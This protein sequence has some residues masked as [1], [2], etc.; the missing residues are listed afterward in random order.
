MTRLLKCSGFGFFLFALTAPASF[1][2]SASISSLTAISTPD[3]LV[4]IPIFSIG[5]TSNVVTVSTVD[6]GNPDQYAQQ[7]NRV[8]ASVTIA[9]VTV[10]PS[11]AV[12]GTFVICGP[13][14]PGCINPT[15]NNFSFVSTG[16][17]FSASS[18]TQL[19]LS[20]VARVGCPLI[21][22]GYFSFCGD[23]RPGAGL[24]Y[25]TDGS[26][27]EI[28]STQD[29]VGTTL[30]ASSLGDG[31]S[32][33]NRVTGCEQSFIESGNEWHFE[34]SWVRNL[35]G[36][37]DI[38]MKNQWLVMNVGDGVTPRGVGGE[39]AMSGTRKLAT[40][41][42]IG[43]RTMLIDMGANPPGTAWPSSGILRFR[44][45]STACWENAGGTNGLCQGTD[46]KDRFNFDG[47][48]VTPTY[49]TATICTNF[50]GQCNSAAAGSVGLSLGASSLIV[51]TTA[52]TSQSQIFVQEDSSLGSVLGITCDTKPGRSYLIL[53]RTP[54]VSFEIVASSTPTG[55]PACLSY[56]I[57]N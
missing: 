10:D 30:W 51:W 4:P 52:V 33:T 50:W 31:N 25:P 37:I 21:P 38:D 40:F 1:A 34:C 32:G 18:S 14:T 27:L 28:I 16:V 54:G 15:T 11:N 5:R 53:N 23:S 24:A 48:V 29:Q 12:N 20:A 7:S 44:N 46:A 6:P 2:Q 47:G 42:T 26:L 8:G 35:G 22:T 55:S 36:S 13:P 17:N 43:N 39:F 56:H 45:G 19:G 41:G 57:L 49:N 3:S 9:N